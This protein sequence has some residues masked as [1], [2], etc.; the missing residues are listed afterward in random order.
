MLPQLE[1]ERAL[2]ATPASCLGSEH[3]EVMRV[4]HESEDIAERIDDGRGLEAGFAVDERLVFLGSEFFH[5][6]ERSHDVV[7]VPVGDGSART[8]VRRLR[9]EFLVDDAELVLEV[10]EAK[11]HVLWRARFWSHEVGPDS[12]ERGVPLHRSRDIF[13]PKTDRTKPS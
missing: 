5:S 8:G 10:A 9:L 6:L 1:S 13:G 3:L 2:E 7:D 4:V 11:L 12:E